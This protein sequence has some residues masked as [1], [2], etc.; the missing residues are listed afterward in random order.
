LIGG[1]QAALKVNVV[2]EETKPHTTE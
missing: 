2:A 1:V